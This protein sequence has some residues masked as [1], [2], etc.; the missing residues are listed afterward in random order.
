M[1]NG[2]KISY[3]HS[4]TLLSS[5]RLS[6][7]FL[8]R[9]R[10]ILR[11]L[12]IIGLFITVYIAAYRDFCCRDW[13]MMLWSNILLLVWTTAMLGFCRIVIL[14]IFFM[15]LPNTFSF[16]ADIRHTFL[17]ILFNYEKYATNGNFMRKIIFLIYSKLK[18]LLFQF[19]STLR[20]NIMYFAILCVVKFSII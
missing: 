13:S 4:F 14:Y 10:I 11:A 3:N 20:I 12:V 19:D 9:P 2:V 5:R 18:V 8:N 6:F 16:C 15:S 1:I 7:S 17:R